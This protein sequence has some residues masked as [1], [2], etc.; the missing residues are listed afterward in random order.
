MYFNN[1]RPDTEE[2]AISGCGYSDNTHKNNVDMVFIPQLLPLMSLEIKKFKLYSKLSL[3]DTN[4]Q[5]SRS[6]IKSHGGVLTARGLAASLWFVYPPLFHL[7]LRVS[8]YLMGTEPSA[9]LCLRTC[10]NSDWSLFSSRSL[11]CGWASSRPSSK[12]GPH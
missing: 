5:C 8:L 4:F 3:S 2:Q 9:Q 1:R 11:F 10:S 12:N 6:V 7:Y